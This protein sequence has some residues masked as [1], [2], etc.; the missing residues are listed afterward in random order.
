M[1]QESI[2]AGFV[3]HYVNGDEFLARYDGHWAMSS[4]LDVAHV[5]ESEAS[6]EVALCVVLDEA[7][8]QVKGGN[9]FTQFWLNIYGGLVRVEEIEIVK[10]L[11]QFPAPVAPPGAT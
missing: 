7:R 11:R 10:R 9:I 6:A 2:R 3:L 8:E 1:S 5:Y 4:S